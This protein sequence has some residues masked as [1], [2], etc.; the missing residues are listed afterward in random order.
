[1]SRALDALDVIRA[2]LARRETGPGLAK[3]GGAEAFR[4]LQRSKAHAAFCAG[5]ESL[6][7][8]GWSRR[9][10]AEHMD[11]HVT[12]LISWHE[13]GET[14]RDQLPAWALAALP[15]EAQAAVM[16]VMLGWADS[17]TERTGTDG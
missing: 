8:A 17:P 13:R 10:V 6:L 1:M 7:L 14:K 2:E 9:R 12:T 15:G 3:G 4:S 11:V 16:R 5:L